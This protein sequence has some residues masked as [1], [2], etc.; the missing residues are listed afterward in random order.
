[1]S[2]KLFIIGILLSLSPFGLSCELPKGEELNIGCSTDCD[3]FYRSRLTMTAWLLGHSVKISNL[4]DSLN[5]ED[6]LSQ[7]DGILLP[8]GADIDPKY[9]LGSVTPDLKEYV[10]KNLHLVKYSEE[11]KRRDPFEYS[12]VKLYSNDEKFSQVPM[13]GICRGLQMMSVA[14]GIPL[15]LDIKTELG[16]KNRMYRFDKVHLTKENESVV[17]SIFPKD[18]ISGFKLHHQGIRVPYYIKHQ[19]DFPKTRVTAYSNNRTIAEA[20]EYTHRPAIGVQYHPERSF[21]SASYPVFKWFLSKACQYK[22]SRSEVQ[23]ND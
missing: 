4:Q 11:G 10:E 23:K 21:P 15:Y 12:L 9:Y 20:I 8:G 17:G 6:S 19:K 13:L 14:Q 1:M 22:K 5:L 7:V 18:K 2:K 16:I 3:F